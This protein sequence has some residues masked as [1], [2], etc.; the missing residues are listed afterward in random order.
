MASQARPVDLRGGH[1]RALLADRR[2][3]AIH[4]RND[5]AEAHAEAAGHLGLHRERA[6]EVR[7]REEPGEGAEHRHGAAG[8]NAAVA[9]ASRERVRE[10]LGDAASASERA[11][12]RRVTASARAEET[13]EVGGLQDVVLVSP[14][15]EEVRRDAARGQRAREEDERGEADAA[16]DEGDAVGR[17]KVVDWKRHAERAE[18]GERRPFG[19]ARERGRSNANDLNDE[20]QRGNA[21]HLGDVGDGERTAEVWAEPLAGLDHREVA[22]FRL[23]ADRAGREKQGIVMLVVVDRPEDA[24]QLVDGHRKGGETLRARIMSEGRPAYHLPLAGALAGLAAGDLLLG[25]N[26]ELQGALPAARLLLV[27]AVAG[28]IVASPLAFLSRAPRT[29]R[30]GAA[31]GAGLLA[32]YGV[33]VEFQRQALHDFVPPGGRGGPLPAAG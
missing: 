18:D 2:K 22:G 24:E 15:V 25:L 9:R 12:V 8:I 33:F 32:A 26:P 19:E 30:A 4:R 14:P 3:S 21:R 23:G 31:L 7:V 5:A 29:P 16:G 1:A 20:L 11:V 6:F 13:L 10:E 17:E 28:A 27:A